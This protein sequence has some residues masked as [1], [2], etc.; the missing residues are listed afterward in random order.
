MPATNDYLNNT[1]PASFNGVPFLMDSDSTESGKLTHKHL[2][3]YKTYSFT[4]ELGQK[5]R[6]FSIKALVAGDDYELNR[7]ALIL[8]L[9]IKGTGIL[10][11]PFYGMCTVI[12]TGFNVTHEFKELGIARF[13][14]TFDESLLGIFPSSIGSTLSE[15]TGLASSAIKALNSNTATN[16]SMNSPLNIQDSTTKCETLNTT[17]NN[18]VSS[19]SN[20]NTTAL[21]DFSV[22]STTYAD[23]IFSDVQ[24]PPSL[25]TAITDLITAYDNVGLDFYQS[26]ILDIKAFQ[27][28]IDDK[29]Y[30]YGTVINAEK[31][32]NAATID[33]TINGTLLI[34]M[35]QNAAM[36]TYYDTN[37]LTQIEND[38]ESHYQWFLSNNNLPNALLR[39]IEQ[40]RTATKQYLNSISVSIPQVIEND[41]LFAPLTVLLYQYYASFDNEAEIVKLNGMQDVTNI[42]GNIT[43]VTNS[44][45]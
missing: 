14:I 24:N 8:A 10:I 18:N 11:H 44:E 5:L 31:I 2:Y 36:I 33:S 12:C 3:P 37:Q 19:T 25:G 39:T 22:A 4:E 17:L 26:Y 6:T 32:K 1:L 41:V 40:L 43:M 27:F 23:N 29:Y 35:Y 20:I 30:N 28:G 42:Q 7:D 38:L 16:Y 13:D 15:I 34:L 45:A 9:R 21:N